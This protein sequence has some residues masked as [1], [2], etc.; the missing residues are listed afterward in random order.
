MKHAFAAVLRLTLV[1]CFMPV[2]VQAA[3]N[4]FQ[5][6]V[7]NGRAP[8]TQGQAPEGYSAGGNSSFD[9]S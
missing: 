8:V 3:P 9:T 2:T 1:L 6:H 7:F 5:N 4:G